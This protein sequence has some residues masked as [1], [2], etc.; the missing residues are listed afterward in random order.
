MKVGSSGISCLYFLS[1]FVIC[2]CFLVIFTIRITIRGRWPNV[3]SSGSSRCQ[4]AGRGRTTKRPPGR[5][6]FKFHKRGISK[7]FALE[8]KSEEDSFGYS[9]LEAGKQV[10][11]RTP[12]NLAD[13]KNDSKSCF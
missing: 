3:G 6:T 2:Y 13:P 9:G 11:D 4:S 12:I 8:R 1:L 5:Q 7:A 10:L